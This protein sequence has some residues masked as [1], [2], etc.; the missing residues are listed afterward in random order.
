[1]VPVYKEEGVCRAT[2]IRKGKR[3]FFFISGG[4]APLSGLVSVPAAPISIRIIP[5]PSLLP[6]YVILPSY[7]RGRVARALAALPGVDMET[8][9]WPPLRVLP[10]ALHAETGES[11]RCGSRDTLWLVFTCTVYCMLIV[12]CVH[13]VGSPSAAPAGTQS[14][15]T[16]GSSRP[17]RLLTPEKGVLSTTDRH[18][19]VLFDPF[20]PV[21][22]H[23]PTCSRAITHV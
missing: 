6:A 5:G 20:E 9:V 22:M 4:V 14:R 12:E 23:L 10:P 3:S 21:S 8:E 17:H 13:A 1:M 15:Q 18:V 7:S 16:P 11:E 2:N 19:I